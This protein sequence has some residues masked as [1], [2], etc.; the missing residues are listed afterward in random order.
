MIGRALAEEPNAFLDLA[1]VEGVSGRGV[2]KPRADGF[3][4]G[5]LLEECEFLIANLATLE[6]CLRDNRLRQRGRLRVQEHREKFEA[7]GNWA[8]GA[9][10]FSQ[11]ARFAQ[12]ALVDGSLGIVFAAAGQAV[13][14]TPS[15]D[16]RR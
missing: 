3:V 16:R 12:A 14:S 4:V 13:Q 2:E 7:R 11:M 5:E 9:V 10:A 6:A 8:Q 1:R 15:H